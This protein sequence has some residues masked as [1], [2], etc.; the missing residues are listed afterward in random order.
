MLQEFDWEVRD[1]KGS[2]KLVADHLS[3]LDQDGLRKNDE[4]MPINDTFH[5]E[6][7]LSVAS[8]EFSWFADIA[9]YLV[10]GILPYG[11]DYRQR[12]KFSYDYKF[13]Y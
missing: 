8:K 2:E 3:R 12:K 4:S 13:Y 6:H 1:K 5:G 7:L 10:S 9:N 11:I